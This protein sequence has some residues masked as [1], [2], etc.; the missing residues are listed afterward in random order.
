MALPFALRNH[1][2]FIFHGAR[3]PPRTFPAE[4]SAE[5]IERCLTPERR[6]VAEK[7]Q[8]GRFRIRSGGGPVAQFS[9]SLEALLAQDGQLLAHRIRTQWQH[10]A[11]HF[12]DG[13]Q[14]VVGNP[15]AQ[16]HELR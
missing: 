4:L 10:G 16:G 5:T 14:I 1:H 9:Q 13:R 2:Q 15:D 12:S 3:Q 7:C 11:E 8:I 6:L